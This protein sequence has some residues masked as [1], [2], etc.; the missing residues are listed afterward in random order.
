MSTPATAPAKQRDPWL[1]NAKMVLVTIVVIGHMIVL[2]PGGDE[3]SRTYD[4]IYYFHIPAFVLVTGYLSRSFR[5]SRRHLLALVTTLV[6]P[7]VI[8]GWLM[9]HWREHLDQVPPGLEWFQNP[10]WPMWYLAA[11]V[12]W[13]LLTPIFR[14]HPVMILV[15]VA[16]SLLGG[17]TN[18]ELFDINRA[19]GFLP[20]FVIGLHL[21]APHVALLRRRLAWVFGVV[22]VLFLWWLAKHTDD[23]WSTQFLYFRA[24]YSELG[25]GDGEGIWIRARL[26]VVA[27]VGSFAVLTLV[28]HKRSFITRM[29]TWSLVVYLCHGFVVRYLEY[30]GYEDWMPGTS[31]WS[32]SITVLVA[33]ALALLIAFEPVARA[34]NYLVDPI[35]SLLASF[36][37]I[38]ARPTSVG[39]G[40]TKSRHETR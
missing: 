2:T 11:V 4:F 27:L 17:L 30:R 5:Y 28:P 21:R 13:R 25:Y 20:F 16:V 12:M 3:Q 6:V 40:G 9:I 29:G 39:R 23:Y 15:A 32:I 7:Y 14:W 34:L 31:W 1:D 38:R 37:R 35:N 24:P 22:G 10:R 36:R 18:H 19:M 33:I 8:F 26:I